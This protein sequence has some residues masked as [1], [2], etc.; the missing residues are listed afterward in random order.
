MDTGA[1][2]EV[3]RVVFGFVLLLFLPGF[4]LSLIFFPRSSDLSIID[5]LVYSTVLSISS[6]IA[7]VLF[8]DVVLGVN[9]TPRNITLFI[10]VFAELALM[11]WWC[12]RWY[13]NR[14]LKK[15]P[16]PRLAADSKKLQKYYSRTTNAAKDRFRQ[17]TRTVV[18]WHESQQSGINHIDH[19][20]LLDIGEEMDIQQVAENKLKVTD[21]VILDPPFPKTRYFE[22][23]IRE[24]TEEGMSLVDDLQIYPVMVT[25]TPDKK[26]LRRF[27]V[28]RGAVHITERIYKKTSTT[29]VQ[30]L[31]SH[32]F[33]I[34]AIVNAE[35]TRDQMVDR[36]LGKLDEIAL[37]YK[38]GAPLPSYAEDRQVLQD[39]YEAEIEQP[40]FIPPVPFSPAL[41][42]EPAVRVTGPEEFPEGPVVRPDTVPGGVTRAPEARPVIEAE[43]VPVPPVI[44]PAGTEKTIRIRPKI[45][46][47][48]E[49]KT[50]PY[51][52]QA[53]TV[54]EPKKILHLR[55][56]RHRAEPTETAQSA[57]DVHVQEAQ[58]A[59]PETELQ[60]TPSQTPV[61][62]EADHKKVP[63]W[64]VIRTSAGP[65]EL[66]QGKV[67]PVSARPEEVSRPPGTVP[68]SVLKDR[69]EH[70]PP[71]PA[72][73]PKESVRPSE[74]L[75]HVETREIFRHPPSPQ[76]SQPKEVRKQETHTVAEPKERDRKTLQKEILKDLDVFDITPDSFAKTKKNIENIEIP[77]KADVDKKLAELKEDKEIS[78]LDLEWLYEE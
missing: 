10:C 63:E 51:Q 17:D 58:K 71:R 5:R 66:P 75:F 14:W 4:N 16:E 44:K 34:F 54:A 24:Y 22:L 57:A 35:D 47:P 21:S 77:K 69:T 12:E 55:E 53:P 6:V 48:D 28:Q 52:P 25:T 13:L 3:M 70:I 31:Y 43:E 32:D 37:A 59:R 26:L 39:S 23:A 62:A 49:A 19:T 68:G 7:L 15:H 9:T 27:V 56:V 74:A 41:P 29:E 50:I 45:L 72:T 8:M 42:P 1:I 38:S 2:I 40:R 76:R 65:G 60:Q 33:H 30:W 20:Y 73:R 46:P 64:P 67:A 36:I 18:L 61:H 78:W 11:V